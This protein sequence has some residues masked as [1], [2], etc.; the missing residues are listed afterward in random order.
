M[1]L[2][3]GVANKLY[4][5]KNSYI[6]GS[7]PI[8]CMHWKVVNQK[9][10]NLSM[11]NLKICSDFKTMFAEIKAKSRT[12]AWNIKVAK[13]MAIQA[14][15]WVFQKKIRK[16][17]LKKIRVLDCFSKVKTKS[18]IK[19]STLYISPRATRNWKKE[20]HSLWRERFCLTQSEF[21]HFHQTQAPFRPTKR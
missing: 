2:F 12:K 10:S 13:I 4:R 19:S 14:K 20:F 8:S 15:R 7:F 18:M 17:K 5:S 9:L 6:C 11:S 16:I 21:R 3:S 1:Y